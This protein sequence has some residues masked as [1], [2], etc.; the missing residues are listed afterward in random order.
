[1]GTFSPNANCARH[2]STCASRATHQADARSSLPLCFVQRFF[3]SATVLPAMNRCT[4]PYETPSPRP[5]ER[6][7]SLT[8]TLQSPRL[9]PMR[10]ARYTMHA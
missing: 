2:C 10:L 9:M 7:N 5:L 3:S 1:M 8:S 4:A 6:M